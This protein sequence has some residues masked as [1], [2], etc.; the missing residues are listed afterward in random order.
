MNRT[1]KKVFYEL[2]INGFFKNYLMNHNLFVDA[3]LLQAHGYI[4]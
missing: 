1:G 2:R 3:H 4:S